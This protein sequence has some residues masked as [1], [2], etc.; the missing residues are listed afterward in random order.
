MFQHITPQTIHWP[1]TFKLICH[2][3][4]CLNNEYVKVCASIIQAFVLQ[5]PDVVAVEFGMLLENKIFQLNWI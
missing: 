3:P 1:S 5:S 4:W 2:A